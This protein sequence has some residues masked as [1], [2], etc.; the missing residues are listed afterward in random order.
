MISL[1]NGQMLVG[2]GGVWYECLFLRLEWVARGTQPVY[3]KHLQ[4]S[5]MSVALNLDSLPSV[6]VDGYEGSFTTTIIAN[7]RVVTFVLNACQVENGDLNWLVDG[8]F[9]AFAGPHSRSEMT[10]EGYR[11][12]T[13]RNYI[14]YF[15]KHNVSLVVSQSE[16]RLNRRFVPYGVLCC[17]GNVR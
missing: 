11:T 14:P 8:K 5:A 2:R 16:T 4:T 15:K 7:T 12:L 9:L 1:R 17:D 10:R 3:K 13:P 6:L